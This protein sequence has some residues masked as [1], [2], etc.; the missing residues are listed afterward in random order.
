[1][2]K[3]GIHSVQTV[4]P[5]L[6]S[7]DPAMQFRS[8]SPFG[9]LVLCGVLVL[10]TATA[11]RTSAG[12]GKIP[13]RDLESAADRGRVALTQHSYLKAEWSIDAY[14]NARMLWGTSAPDPEKDPEGYARAFAAHYGLHPAP[15]PNDGLP[16]GLRWSRSKDGSKTGIQVDCLACHGGSIGGR[17]YVGLGNSQI[18]YDSLFRDLFRADGRRPP[19]VPFVINTA[20]GTTNAGMMSVVLLSVRNPDLSLRRFPLLLGANLPE[21]DA[22]AWWGLKHKQT[23][24][25]D[26]RTPAASARAIMQFMLAEKSLQEFRELEPTFSDIRAYLLSL[27]PP[28]YPFPIDAARAD[29]GRQVFERAC[30]RCHGTYGERRSYPN[31]IVPLEIIG[32]DPARSLGI[33]ERAVAHYNSTWFGEKHPV[34][35]ERI[36]YQAPPLDGVWATAPYLHNGSIPTLYALLKSSTRPGRFTRPPSTDFEHYDQDRVGWKFRVVDDAEWNGRERSIHESRFIYDTARFG[37]GNQGHTF[38][39]RLTEDQRRDLIEYLKTL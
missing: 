39:D 35:L 21:L 15:Y 38:G 1:M 17:S 2:N 28:K 6:L 4:E 13:P 8:L 16:M 25:Q 37:L 27:E 9:L 29:R 32:T 7:R 22:P 12:E 3:R 14:R 19:L 18:D 33:S 20:R 31:K 26:G 23:M 10:D 5:V 34:S 36:G 24:Y 30:A 11:Q